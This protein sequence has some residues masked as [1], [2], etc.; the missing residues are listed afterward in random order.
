M[1]M[2]QFIGLA[3]VAGLLSACA[4]AMTAEQKADLEREYRPKIN[5]FLPAC[6]AAASGRKVDYASITAMGY[7]PASSLYRGGERFVRKDKGFFDADGI[8]I[9]RGVGCDVDEKLITGVSGLGLQEAGYIWVRAL[10]NAGYRDT[11]DSF[12]S[13]GFTANGVPME[14]DGR[15][16]SGSMT[17]RFRRIK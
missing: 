5:A 3:A 2:K 1:K 12:T 14:F 6:I 8:T 13:Y 15:E 7:V 10:D 17:F 4:P 9:L 11:D 16:G